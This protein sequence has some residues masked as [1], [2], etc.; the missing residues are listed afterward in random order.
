MQVIADPPGTHPSPRGGGRR[1][2][3]PLVWVGGGGGV[4]CEIER[5]NSVS[6]L[7]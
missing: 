4:I 2:V 3:S 7:F 6:C 5:L 1:E